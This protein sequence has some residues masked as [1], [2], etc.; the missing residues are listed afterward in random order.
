MNRSRIIATAL[1]L[2]ALGALLPL[3]V[4]AY[5]S[6]ARAVSQEQS[7]LDG[8]ATRALRN[9]TTTLDQGR[10]VVTEMENWRGTP[11]SAEHIEQMRRVAINSRYTEQVGYLENGQP[12]C[13]SWGVFTSPPGTR[14]VAPPD[15]DLPDGF[16]VTLRTYPAITGGDPVTVLQRGNIY[17]LINTSRLTDVI[18][19]DRVQLGVAYGGKVVSTLRATDTD[20]VARVASSPTAINDSRYLHAV[21]RQDA[22]SAVVL[23]PQGNLRTSLLKELLWLLPIGVIISCVIVALVIRLLRKRLSPLAELNIA[24]QQREFVVFYQPIIHLTTGACIAAEALVRWRRP[25]G[26][27][28]RPDLFI[29]LA[30]ESGLILPITDQVVE[31]CIRDLRELLL[32]DR[33]MHVAIN[34]SANDITTGRFIGVLQQALE[35]SGIQNEQI[36]LEATERGFVDV[37]AASANLAKAR[38]LGFGIAIDDFGTGYSSLQYLERLPTDALKID[39]CFIAAI[40]RTVATSSVISHIIDMAKTVG[41]K[42]VAEGVETEAQAEYLKAHGVEFAQGWLYA[43]AM[44]IED[45]LAFVRVEAWREAKGAQDAQAS[46]HAAGGG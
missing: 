33:S 9:V 18:V 14:R 38:A 44:P 16:R 17:V 37:D 24:V 46:L 21:A 32:A 30:E 6:W 40:G 25:D 1:L 10:R 42:V 20:F 27:M 4:A 41:L 2:A 8:Y 39:K 29:P 43:K 15:A 36:W 12:R 45:F 22:W 31:T 13:S 7:L 34:L 28:V 35:G 23:E 5:A 3:A 26:T 19:D 11:C